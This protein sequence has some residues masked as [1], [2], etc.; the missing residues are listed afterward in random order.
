MFPL[1]PDQ[2]AAQVAARGILDISTATIRQISSLAAALEQVAAEPVVHMELGNPGLPAAQ[3]GI[4]AQIEALRSGVASRY[5]NINGIPQLKEAASAF[6]KAFLDIDIPPRTIVPTVGSM[7]GCFTTE[8]LLGQSKPGCDTI[9]FLLPGFPAQVH[10][11]KVLGFKTTGF[12][13]L[14]HRGDALE[15]PLRALFEQGNIAGL[16]YSNPNNPAWTNLTER[17]LEI[18]G[19]LATEYDV[20]VVEDHAYMGMDYRHRFGHPGREPFIPTVAKYT[21]NYI[22]LCSASKIFSYAGE[23]IALVCMS[24]AVFDRNYPYLEEF[25]EM[26]TYG[27]AY[28]FGVLYATSSGTSHSA[29]YALAAMLDAATRGTLDFVDD[30]S[31]YAHRGKRAKEIFQRH[32]FHIVY[33]DDAGTPIS[34]GF[35]FTAGYGDMPSDELQLELLRY[36]V[37]AISLP[38][39]GSKHNGLRIC[40]STMGSDDLFDM[41]DKRLELFN[42]DHQDILTN[43]EPHAQAQ[44]S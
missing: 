17:E 18:I 14:K 35:F 32:G 16:V 41:L 8:M 22:L 7:Q 33:A 9:A 20:I 21:D 34:D 2:L 26:P 3:A 43:K 10:Q 36:G 12:D 23:R 5:P 11:A 39:T 15:A 44:K 13:I 25:Y 1:N 28:I 29:Q 31:E 6:F 30:C 27:D 4:D 40:I 42:T 24:P 38:S 19:R 37:S